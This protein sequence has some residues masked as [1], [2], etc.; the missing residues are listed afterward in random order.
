[1]LCHVLIN[2]ISIISK[3]TDTKF[4]PYNS[5]KEIGA[6]RFLNNLD[7]GKAKEKHHEIRLENI[8]KITY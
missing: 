3:E 7:I 1:M 2:L 6:K 4:Q 8:L 5:D